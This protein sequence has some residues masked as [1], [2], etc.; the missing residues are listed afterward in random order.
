M[1]LKTLDKLTAGKL[2][3]EAS[4]IPEISGVRRMSKEQ[5]IRAIA[6]SY[7]ISLEGR[8]RGG[9]GKPDLKRQIRD[10]GPRIDEALK[11]KDRGGAAKLRRQKKRLKR[12]TRHVPATAAA[13]EPAAAPSS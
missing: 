8:R 10:L 9:A 1:D 7:E 11:A 5:L 4:K 12:Q 13:P 2:R 3:E 6:S